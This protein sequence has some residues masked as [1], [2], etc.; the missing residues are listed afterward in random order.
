MTTLRL[1]PPG[2][3]FL[4]LHRLAEMRQAEHGR[5]GPAPGAG[6]A[7]SDEALIEA[8]VKRGSD[9]HFGALMARYKQKVHHI[10]LSVLGASRQAEAED[11][12][13]EVFIRLYQRLD[14]FRG[15]SR[16]STWLYRLSFNTCMDHLRRERR[17]A[18]LDLDQ[19]DEPDS[20][21]ETTRAAEERE[22]AARVMK[23]VD[24]LPGTQ[25]MMVRLHYW[26]G[27]RVREISE[28]MDCPEGTVKVYLQRA[29]KHL[30]GS[31]GDLLDA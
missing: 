12:A 14:S 9:Q 6:D 15:E 29:R 20:G 10:A 19:I 2:A 18:A 17:F 21:H 23:A 1:N 8:I 4:L 26:L 13:Q 30:A 31:L 25:R 7:W 16:F 22:R 11:V 28:V 3:L 27:Y 24:T 5:P